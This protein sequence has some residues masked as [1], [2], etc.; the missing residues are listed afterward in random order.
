MRIGICM[1]MSMNKYKDVCIEVRADMCIRMCI[2]RCTCMRNSVSMVKWAYKQ[3]QTWVLAGDTGLAS[4]VMAVAACA[5]RCSGQK[6][7]YRS[8]F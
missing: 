6:I 2:D 5:D 7:A 8:V 4:S 3:G 1:D